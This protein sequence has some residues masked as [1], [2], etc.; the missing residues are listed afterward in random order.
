MLGRRKRFIHRRRR[1]RR[2]STTQ[3][4]AYL[5][6]TKYDF[7]FLYLQ[8]ANALRTLVFFNCL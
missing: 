4:F 2:F 7:F 6:V 5:D 1:R 3:I 8:Y